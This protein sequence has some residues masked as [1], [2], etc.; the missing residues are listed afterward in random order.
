MRTRLPALLVSL[1]L[2]G[3]AGLGAAATNLHDAEITPGEVEERS[4]VD[5][6]VAFS[7]DAV[8]GDGSTD[9]VWIQFPDGV[10]LS[11]NGATVAD[12]ADGSGVAVTS[13]IEVVDGPD[14]DGVEETLTFA[15]SPDTGGTVDVRVNVSTAV[16][17]PDR[18]NVEE[19]IQVA[20]EDSSRADIEMTSIGR[21]K[22]SS[23]DTPTGS[24]GDGTSTTTVEDGTVTVTPVDDTGGGSTGITP[25]FGA[26][27]VVVGLLVGAALA[28][29]RRQ[30]G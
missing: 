29:W 9:R 24:P 1:L 8:S 26:G 16:S 30:E 20:V 21:M 19:P 6:H 2:V 22:L 5:H 10:D 15:I 17:W 28:L 4:T 18:D 27:L 11:P 7:V 13:S 25:G 14:E 12:R 23:V 3:A